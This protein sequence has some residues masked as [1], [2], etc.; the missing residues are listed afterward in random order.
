MTV[1][2]SHLVHPRVVSLLNEEP[3]TDELGKVRAAMALQLARK[4]DEAVDDQ[5]TGSAQATPGISKEL[6]AVLTDIAAARGAKEEF[7][8]GIFGDN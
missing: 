4:L 1:E 8:A 6:R 3:A 7:I 2:L 5:S